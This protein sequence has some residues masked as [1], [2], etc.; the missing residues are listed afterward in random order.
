MQRDFL[1]FGPNATK[2]RPNPKA[3]PNPVRAH[4]HSVFLTLSLTKLKKSCNYHYRLTTTNNPEVKLTQKY[5]FLL[6]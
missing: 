6:G 3:N 4:L 5:A 1:N 2:N